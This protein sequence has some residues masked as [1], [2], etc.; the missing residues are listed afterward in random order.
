VQVTDSFNC[1]ATDSKLV[2]VIEKCNEN[3]V[4]V[5]NLFTPNANGRNDV[6]K[7]L[8]PGV[9]N[10]LNFRIYDRWGK[11]L[12]ESNDIQRGWD[13]TFE[14]QPLKPGV[15]LYYVEVRCI[16]NEKTYKKG[17]VTLLR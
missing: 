9:D 12:F 14:G 3:A 2:R 5:P 6:L 1:Q 8:G 17:D 11:L 7:V 15:Y 10:V 13:G 16:N 4:F